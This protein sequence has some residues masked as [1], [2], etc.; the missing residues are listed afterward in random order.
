MI[1][2][3]YDTFDET[4]NK[5]S[6]IPQE[7]LDIL[8]EELPSTFMY[9]RNDEGEYIAGPRPDNISASMILKVDID[10][11]FVEEYLKDIPA[12]K[13]AEYVYR[14]QLRV[15]VTNARIGDKEKQIP[16]E[17]TVGNPLT[18]PVEISESFMY[19][20]P[21]PPARE[22][23]FE[24]EEGDKITMK[25]AR[26]PYD[27]LEEELYTNID[28]PAMQIKFVLADEIMSSKATYS[29]F[30]TKATTV[31]DALAAIH[32]FNGLYYGTVT[33]NG[34]KMTESLVN[35]VE[36][37]TEQLESMKE[38]WTTAKKLEDKLGVEF[39]PSAD[40]PMEDLEF[41]AQLDN[42]LNNNNPVMWEH[43]FDHFHVRGFVIKDEKLK[44]ILGKEGVEFTFIEGP[45]HATLLGAE[46]ELYSETKLTNMVMTNI[47]WD[48]DEKDSGE[49]YVSDPIGSKWKL[50]RRYM[51][52]EQK[53]E[54]E[55]T[56]RQE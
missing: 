27:S 7:V 31:S 22:V 1:A 34:H 25:I 18:D 37:D 35:K 17:K 42:C 4:P 23:V 5:G 45:I 52:K 26:K 54:L 41:F 6:D 30:P 50:Y 11:K 53:D 38:L 16:I 15:P 47:V 33:I 3:F 48:S 49:I 29:V 32:L 28:F 44:D 2:D 43:P 20:Q 13:W 55:Q 14:M 10:S 46:F 12:E 24:T 56:D 19:P 40:F 8:S 9:Y 21:F 51:T 39:N 36:I